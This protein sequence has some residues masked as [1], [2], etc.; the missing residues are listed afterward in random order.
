MKRDWITFT[1]GF[2]LVLA[3]TVA[4]A[5]RE[6]IVNG[7]RLSGNELA[8]LEQIHCGAIP[9]GRYWLDEDTGHWGRQGESAPLGN[10]RENCQ[11]STEVPPP[12]K[13]NGF[14]PP[15]ANGGG[16][17]STST[18][19]VMVEVFYATDRKASL[20]EKPFYG[21]ERGEVQLGVCEISIPPD[22]KMGELEAPKWW[23]LEFR[24][25]RAPERESSTNLGVLSESP[26]Q[27]GTLVQPRSLRVC[28]RL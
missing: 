14:S 28:A 5:E 3:V 2:V 25:D 9:D 27:G 15:A 11:K 22:H 13:R 17:P 7:K 6:V 16:T 26:I 1:I 10:I 21:T 24:E 8:R 23:K 18:K 4:I 20:S 19:K 12:S